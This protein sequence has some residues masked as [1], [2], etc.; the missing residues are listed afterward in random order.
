MVTRAIQCL[1]RLRT[2]GYRAISPI[3]RCFLSA[4]ERRELPPLWLRRHVGQPA[5]FRSAAHDTA[6]LIDRL[7]L[8]S[9][10]AV[11]LDIGCGCGAMVS[12]LLERVGEE[13][14]YVGFDVH[15]PSI[16]WCRRRW[17]G[18]P[19]VDF[20]RAEIPSPYSTGTVRSSL[21]S[22]RFP[23]PDGGADLV[24]AK[25]VFTHILGGELPH[26][27]EEI[28]RVLAPGGRALVSL[29][30]FDDGAG[31]VPPAF[32]FP[33]DPGALER[34][35][36]RGWPHAAVAYARSHSQKLIENAGLEVAL[37]IDG[38]WPGTEREI[39]GQDLLV[40]RSPQLPAAATAC[41][42][43]PV[44]IAATVRGAISAPPLSPAHV[45]PPPSSPF[46]AAAR[47]ID[48]PQSRG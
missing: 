45:D 40:L 43:S 9:P 32:P 27:L 44:P 16:R 19:R 26:Y 6:E 24:L 23:V 29:F 38:F 48:P 10:G 2:L 31:V 37:S 18:H 11:V 8:L 25:S 39:R 14:R 4:Q 41:V 36:R 15:G 3:E 21:I 17:S 5:K 1:R 20:H 30:Q 35:R 28:R 34:W 7:A 46:L 12:A 33:A 22:Y 47:R 13:G 42:A